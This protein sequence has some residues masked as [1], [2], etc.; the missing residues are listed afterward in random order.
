MTTTKVG[1]W[2]PNHLNLYRV[3]VFGTLQSRSREFFDPMLALG[4]WKTSDNE[5]LLKR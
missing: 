3:S 4:A 2:S 1:P 5:P